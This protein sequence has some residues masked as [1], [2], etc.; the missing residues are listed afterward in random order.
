MANAN[1][2]LF[3]AANRHQT[4]LIRYGGSSANEI[5]KILQEAEKD[6]VTRIAGRVDRLGPSAKNTLG[7]KRLQAILADIRGQTRDLTGALYS[8]TRGDLMGLAKQEVDI[9]SRRLTEAVGVDLGNFRVPP[10]TLRTLVEKRAVG[11]KSLRRWFTRLGAD[12]MGRLESAVNLGVIE[13]DTISEITRRFRDAEAVTRRSATTMVRTHINHVANQSREAL[14]EANSDIVEK[15]RWTATLD[16][17]TS[18]I[19]KSRDGKTYD[20]DEGP[21]PPAHPNCRSITTPVL[22]SWESLAKPGA[23]KQGR[24]AG[25]IDKIFQK[26]L[27]KQGF[28]PDE[29]KG[30]KGNTHFPMSDLNNQEIADLMYK[31]LAEKELN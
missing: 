28:A 29:I 16:G 21:R 1:E 31:W 20:L 3:D 9:A 10:E 23:L 17:R 11:G 24:G 7:S 19:C 5:V 27:K 13:G 18:A 25:D 8:K 15:V 6:L 22:K 2:A 4:F 30:I 14:Y 26:K 12:R